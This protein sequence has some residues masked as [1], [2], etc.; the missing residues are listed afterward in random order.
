MLQIP[1]CAHTYIYY[2]RIVTM[3]LYNNYTTL[4]CNLSV[5]ITILYINVIITQPYCV[6]YLVIAL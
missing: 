6:I 5:I 4:L 2:Y 3:A 1:L